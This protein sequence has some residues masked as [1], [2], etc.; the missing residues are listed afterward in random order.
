MQVGDNRT[1]K[2]QEDL[3][4]QLF[5]EFIEITPR[6]ISIEGCIKGQSQQLENA[7]LF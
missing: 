1:K 3:N 4:I 6:Q 2:Q 7:K 5:Y